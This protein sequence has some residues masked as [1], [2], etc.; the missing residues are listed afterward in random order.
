MNISSRLEMF[1]RRG[2]DDSRKIHQIQL[3]RVTFK[4]IQWEVAAQSACVALCS[5][6]EKERFHY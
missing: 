3:A 6:Q 2:T 1:R 5:L 4:E